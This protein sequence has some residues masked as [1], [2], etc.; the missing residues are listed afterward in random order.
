MYVSTPCVITNSGQERRID[1]GSVWLYANSLIPRPNFCCML[2]GLVENKDWTCSL[3][4]LGL[5]YKVYLHGMRS[6]PSKVKVSRP[7]F[8]A[9]LQGT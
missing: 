8:L 7:Y 6:Q 4:K 9:S 3:R 1:I 2:C 5:H